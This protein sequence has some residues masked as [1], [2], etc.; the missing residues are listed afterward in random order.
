MN[1]LSKK[2]LRMKNINLFE[3][4]LDIGGSLS[5]VAICLNNKN[6]DIRNNVKKNYDYVEEVEL[7]DKYLFIKF[8]QTS[9]FQLDGISFLRS[10]TYSL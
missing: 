6:I 1:D 7:D 10:K 2:I 8:F 4:G 5:K 9:K 3:I